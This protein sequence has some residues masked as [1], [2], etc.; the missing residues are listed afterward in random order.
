MLQWEVYL[1]HSYFDSLSI[2][3]SQNPNYKTHYP[4]TFNI[5]RT[6]SQRT[7]YYHWMRET[8]EMQVGRT[9]LRHWTGEVSGP[10]HTWVWHSLPCLMCDCDSLECGPNHTSNLYGFILS[11]WFHQMQLLVYTGQQSNVRVRWKC[12]MVNTEQRTVSC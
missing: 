10:G 2:V 6:Q 4:V 12:T 3:E 7:Q 1:P 11:S 5:Y 8:E 9:Q